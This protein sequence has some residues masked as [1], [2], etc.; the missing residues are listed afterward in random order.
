MPKSKQQSKGKNGKHPGGRPSKYKPEM[1]D[2][3]VS[4]MRKGASKC[5]VAAALDISGETLNQWEKSN[6]EFSEAIKRGEQLSQAWWMT[7]G[8][9]KLEEP[10]FNYTGWYMNMKNRF[11]WRDKTENNSTVEIGGEVG[12]IL[13]PAGGRHA[14]EQKAA[15]EKDTL[16]TAG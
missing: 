10:K 12:C 5:E 8:R 14:R 11:G 1:C 16:G 13:I 3:V 7:K 4:M 9:M 6:R 15:K 2:T